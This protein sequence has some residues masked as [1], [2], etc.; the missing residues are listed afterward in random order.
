ME[1]GFSNPTVAASHRYKPE[2]KTGLTPQQYR[3]R[4]TDRS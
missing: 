1:K 2:K 4:A 3:D